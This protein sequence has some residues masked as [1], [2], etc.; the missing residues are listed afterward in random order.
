MFEHVYIVVIK[1]NGWRIAELINT[2]DIPCVLRCHSRVCAWLDQC[3]DCISSVCVC[4]SVWIRVCIRMDDTCVH[5]CVVCGCVCMCM[6]MCVHVVSAC[7]HVVS[8]CVN[9]IMDLIT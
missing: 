5:V 3:G 1:R 8:A 2:S 9:L 4:A 7:V 6:Y